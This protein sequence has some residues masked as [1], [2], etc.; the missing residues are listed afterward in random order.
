MSHVK[1]KIIQL[2]CARH[3]EYTILLLFTPLSLL[4]NR[5]KETVVDAVICYL[6]PTCRTEA[7]ISS[8]AKSIGH[9][10]WVPSSELTPENRGC[11]LA[12]GHIP[13][14]GTAHIQWQVDVGT[15]AQTPLLCSE[16]HQ[17]ATRAPKLPIVSSEASAA[18]QSTPHP[19]HVLPPSAL[20][21]KLHADLSLF[22]GELEQPMKEAQVKQHS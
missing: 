7:F 5:G 16:Q 8:A 21:H 15:M 18:S 3:W 9:S 6:E 12:Q 1:I 2:L 20:P 19:S 17:K 10:Q 22:P 13:Y 11:D 14:L 4:C